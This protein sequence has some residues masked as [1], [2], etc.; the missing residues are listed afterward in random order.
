VAR[1]LVQL[2]TPI[3]HDTNTHKYIYS[4]CN[5][6]P[7][8]KLTIIMAPK[9]SWPINW[10]SYSWIHPLELHDAHLGILWFADGEVGTSE[11]VQDQNSFN[12]SGNKSLSWEDSKFCCTYSQNTVLDDATMRRNCQVIEQWNHVG[13]RVYGLGN[14]KLFKRFPWGL[15]QDIGNEI[16]TTSGNR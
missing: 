4:Y 5:V 16:G 3:T 15:I 14:G 11:G 1:H 10:L 9:Q 8:P 7:P 2:L 6:L 13:F 12:G